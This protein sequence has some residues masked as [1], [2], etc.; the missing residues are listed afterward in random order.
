MDSDES[1]RSNE[2][3]RYPE[4]MPSS[5]D[6][7]HVSQAPEQARYGELAVDKSDHIGAAHRIRRTSRRIATGVARFLIMASIAVL[8]GI[9]AFSI[10]TGIYGVSPVRRMISSGY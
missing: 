9:A 8:T 2:Q 4:T 1:P 3:A 10:L 6:G 7:S 5:L